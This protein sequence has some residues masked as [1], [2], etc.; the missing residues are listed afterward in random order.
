M[1]E[2]EYSQ[3]EESEGGFMKSLEDE[4][5][6]RL[7]FFSATLECSDPQVLSLLLFWMLI[8]QCVYV[9][10]SVCMYER[11]YN[12]LSLSLEYHSISL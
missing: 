6:W 3:S 5:L 12:S 7:N 2:L 4:L 10:Q 11:K 9:L 1:S 8:K